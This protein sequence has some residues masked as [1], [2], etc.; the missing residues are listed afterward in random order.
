VS[1]RALASQEREQGPFALEFG[2]EGGKTGRFPDEQLQS[3]DDYFY[4]EWLHD[5]LRFEVSILL[6][7]FRVT[8]VQFVHHYLE[9]LVNQ[10]LHEGVDLPLRHVVDYLD[11]FG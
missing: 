3:V 8:P 4:I 11:R 9:D 5:P 6:L 1:E 10:T 7:L 2:N